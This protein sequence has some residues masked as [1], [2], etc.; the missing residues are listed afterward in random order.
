MAD[1]GE[2][3]P[4]DNIVYN[5]SSYS[6]NDAIHNRY[7]YYLPKLCSEAAQEYFGSNDEIVFFTRSGNKLSPNFTRLVWAGDQLENWEG[8][9]GFKS[10]LKGMLNIGL[11][12]AQLTHSDVGGYIAYSFY[13]FLKIERTQELLMRWIEFGAFSVVFR[14]HEGT[15]PD[16]TPQIYSN[17]EITGFFS[18]FTKVYLSWKEYR[19]FLM[20]EAFQTGMP[21]LRHMVIH[22]LHDPESI[23]LNEQYMLGEDLLVA[24]VFEEGS[25][26][27]MVYFPKEKEKETEWVHLWR[28]E[29]FD[30]CGCWREIYAPIGKPAVFVRGGS[31]WGEKIDTFIKENLE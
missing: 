18:K 15:A 31:K 25:E 1:F 4:I 24:P 20:E 21:V 19:K 8:G 17:D 5:D 22:Y 2:D 10:A 14:T 9:N 13:G 3:P 26:K 28:G 30:S 23:N 6:E 29:K 27:K 16:N 7:T 11:S 12:G